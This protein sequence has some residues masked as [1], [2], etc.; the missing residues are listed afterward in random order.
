MT[1][2]FLFVKFCDPDSERMD[3]A[4]KKKVLPVGFL[5]DSLFVL[6]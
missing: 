2:L 6:R 5:G 1:K 3:V 4:V